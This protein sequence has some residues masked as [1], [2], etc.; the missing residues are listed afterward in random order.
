MYPCLSLLILL[1]GLFHFYFSECCFK[2][3]FLFELFLH[4]FIIHH[5]IVQVVVPLLVVDLFFHLLN[6]VNFTHVGSRNILFFAQL[7]SV[8]GSCNLHF[9]VYSIDLLLEFFFLLYFYLLNFANKFV[10]S[11]IK[12]GHHG[13]SVAVLGRVFLDLGVKGHHS[14]GTTTRHNLT[15]ILH[16]I[17]MMGWFRS[18]FLNHWFL[19]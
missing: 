5:K 12:T 14:C 17:V 3:I 10:G 4:F 13:I 2:C 11:S 8:S 15:L 18:L 19:S 6:F 7:S 16:R 9:V 1:L